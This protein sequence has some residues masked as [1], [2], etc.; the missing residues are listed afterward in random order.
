MKYFAY[1]IVLS[2]ISIA[3]FACNK[4]EVVPAPKQTV[5][6]NNRFFGKINSVDSELTKNVNGYVGSSYKDVI[7][8]SNA[9]D[10]VVYYSVFSSPG[11]VESLAVGHGSII[12][13]LDS[14]QYSPSLQVFSNFYT[15][16]ANQT[17]SFSTN[18]QHGFVV[19]YTD[20]AGVVWRSNQM[21]TYSLENVQYH[22]LAIKSDASGDYA[23]FTVSFG[24]YL[25]STNGDSL[26]LSDASYIGWYQR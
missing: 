4:R 15:N 6:L 17:P 5:Q 2:V 13:E 22:D 10:S 8:H 12:T 7:F 23:T 1:S 14:A 16:Y 24:A 19:S 18:G 26:L 25:Y 20:P 11:T 9:P 21:H 3:F